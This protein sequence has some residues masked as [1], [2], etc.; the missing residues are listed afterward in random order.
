MD[1]LNP[2]LQQRVWSRVMSGPTACQKLLQREADT[3]TTLPAVQNTAQSRIAPVV[4]EDALLELYT[5]Q[6]RSGMTYRRLSRM[7]RGCAASILSQLAWEKQQ[8]GCR[9][10]ALYYI[11]TGK[12]PCATPPAPVPICCVS[13]A[14]RSAYQEEQCA[15][16]LYR[17][18]AE[19]A[20]ADL[21]ETLTQMAEE[22][23]C[24]ARQVLRA[25]Q[26]CL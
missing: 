23:D 16:A 7:L 17:R 14:L 8:S 1:P 9:L 15:A 24:H 2:E 21:A 5:A 11:R 13:E 6:L 20:E 26:S 3:P 10:A 22:A 4:D 18:Y 19:T 25:L 12:K